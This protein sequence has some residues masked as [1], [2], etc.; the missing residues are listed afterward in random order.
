M[1]LVI[2]RVVARS[3]KIN[4]SP[5]AGTKAFSVVANIA[6][7]ADVMYAINADINAELNHNIEIMAGP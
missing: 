7:S 3:L 6:N 4:V 5:F 1:C 2:D